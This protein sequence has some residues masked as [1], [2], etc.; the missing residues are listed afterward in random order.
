MGSFKSSNAAT[1]CITCGAHA[2]PCVHD[3][4]Y[5]VS[6][7]RK[8]VTI[9]YDGFVN[10]VLGGRKKLPPDVELHGDEA[11][12]QLKTVFWPRVEGDVYV[13]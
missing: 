12:T 9:R 1:L 8:I 6:R 4:L 2:F 5:P 3:E 11:L 10:I 13:A 7:P